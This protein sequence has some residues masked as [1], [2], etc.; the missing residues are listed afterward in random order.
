MADTL[1][2]RIKGI[3][4]GVALGDAM[5]M[6][7]ELWTRQMIKEEFPAGVKKFSKS[8]NKGAIIRDMKAGQI[9][10]DTINTIFLIKMLNKYH[11]EVSVED[12]IEQLQEWSAD[13]ELAEL[14]SG[15]STRKALDLLKKGVP[16]TQTGRFGTTNGAAMKIAPIGIISDYQNL[17]ELVNRVYQICIPTHNTSI[18]IAGAS[19][20]AAAI[21][22]TSAGG[23]DLNQIFELAE[24]AI[25]LGLKK[26][27][28]VA[29]ASLIRRLA[30]VRELVDNKSEE[31]V[32]TTLYE[33]LGTGVE[34]I[35]TIPSVFAIVYL[36]QGNPLKAAQLSA[37]LGG[38]TDTIGAISTAICGGIEPI[39]DVQIIQ[40]LETVNQLDFDEL[41]EQLIHFSPYLD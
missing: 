18:A 33:V 1:I 29:T 31:E 2:Q 28:D 17:E 24:T 11:G 26:G 41:A 36:A 13:S 12:Y 22:Y 32:M 35:E 27:Y 14:V 8:I 34:T 15:P 5:G 25:R 4:V 39:N 7:T 10:D 40:T 23:K 19:S 20:V 16:I 9:T 6:P 37:S 21:S 3:L 30:I 38:D